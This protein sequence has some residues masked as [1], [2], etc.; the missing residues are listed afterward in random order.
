MAQT[1]GAAS[2]RSAVIEYSI[3]SSTWTGISGV[4]NSVEPSGHARIS[5]EAYTAEGDEA[6]VTVGKEEPLELTLNIVYSE[7]TTEGYLL[8]K[9]LKESATACKVRWAPKGS[10]TGNY[11]YT[12]Y[13]GYFVDVPP[14]GGSVDDGGPILVSAM[15]RSPGWSAAA[16]S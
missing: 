1:T 8:L 6:I 16:I 9:A 3:D 15:H 7:T 13:T 4:A 5:G 10:S 2:M 11:R 12:T 14:P